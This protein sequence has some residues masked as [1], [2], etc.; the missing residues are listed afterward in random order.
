M[1]GRKKGVWLKIECEF[2]LKSEDLL[3][4]YLRYLTNFGQRGRL[5]LYFLVFAGI[6]SFVLWD[7]LLPGYVLTLDMVFSPNVKIENLLYGLGEVPVYGGSASFFL[8]LNGVS[9]F[10]PV[11][12]IQKL[13]LFFD[14]FSIR[15]FGFLFVSSGEQC[16][17]IFRGSP[18]HDE[19]FC[20]CQVYGWALVAFAGVRC[21]AFSG[22]VYS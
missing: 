8:V 13:I 7:L 20:L 15:H 19:S 22:Q 10:I 4:S 6:S 3:M 18:L 14:F 9:K 2:R 11:W 21:Y 5:A 12:I 1:F 17:Q 16:W